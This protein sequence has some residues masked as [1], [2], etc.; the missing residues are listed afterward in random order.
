[1]W[2]QRWRL[3]GSAARASSGRARGGGGCDDHR[4]LQVG[5]N[6]GITVRPGR[7]GRASGLSRVPKSSR[8]CADVPL[9]RGDRTKGVG[10]SAEYTNLVRVPGL[11]AR[12]VVDADYHWW[13]LGE[14]L[15]EGYD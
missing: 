7:P 4:R 10:M 12:V 9:L 13:D 3:P 14:L 11:S 5:S 1:M 6:A 15:A 8:R 2:Q